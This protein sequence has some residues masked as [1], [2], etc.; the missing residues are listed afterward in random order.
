MKKI[1]EITNL[2]K[3]FGDIKAVNGLSLHVNEGDLFAFLGINGAGKSTTISMMCGNLKIDKGSI[4]ICGHDVNKNIDT[5]K[6]LIGVVF[7]DTVLDK[8]ISVYDNL[9]YRAGLYGIT[10]TDFKKRFQELDKLFDLESIK[11]QPLGKLSGGQRRRVDIARAIIHKPQIL[12]LDEPTTG[13]DPG[14]RKKI[15]SIVNMLRK[16]YKTTIF[17]TTH[18]MEEAADADY[19]VILDK[20]KIIA[21]G[22]SIELKNKF[23]SDVIYLYNTNEE[24]VKKLNAPYQ[25]IKNTYK[26]KIDSSA[27]ATDLIVAHPEIF[28]DYEIIKGKMDDVFLA[29]T[30]HQLETK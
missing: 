17:L 19:T 27:K 30:G 7:Q 25:A 6:Q 22:T 13:L 24:T 5:I 2:H 23:A 26:I 28:Q 4:S 9:K 14:T 15:W 1:I 8:T 3:S 29:A 21:E 20:G 11:K 12:I 10:G 18:Y 16:Q